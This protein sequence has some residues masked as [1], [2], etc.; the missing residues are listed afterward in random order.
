MSYIKS[1]SEYVSSINEE[2]SIEN[3]VKNIARHLAFDKDVVKYL[4]T[5]RSKREIGWRD[6]LDTKLRG[7]DKD[8]ITYI[9]KNMVANLNPKITG[10]VSVK[11]DD[12]DFDNK[13]TTLSTRLDNMS[14]DDKIDDINRRLEDVEDMFGIDPDDPDSLKGAR[15]KAEEL[16]FEPFE[17][18]E[19]REV[20]HKNEDEEEE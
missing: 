5:T 3:K 7:E 13:E 2:K 16:G 18:D 17:R 12:G 9:T 10:P 6:L 15:K 1:F 11:F 4:N 19:N 14:T 20:I 8:F